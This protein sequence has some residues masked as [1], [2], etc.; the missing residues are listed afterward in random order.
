MQKRKQPTLRLS[1]LS[2]AIALA[3]SGATQSAFAVDICTGAA[4]VSVGTAP[5]GQ[6]CSLDTVDARLNVLGGGEIDQQ[7]YVAAT[8]ATISNAG[9]ISASSTSAIYFDGVDLAASLTNS[10][11]IEGYADTSSYAYAYGVNLAELSGSVNNSGTIRAIAEATG[12]YANASA[13]MINGELS[14]ALNNTGRI[15]A[16]AN[17]ENANAYGVR[18]YG[19]L[20]GKIVNTG[21]LSAKAITTDYH[22]A[23]ASTLYI[24]GDVSGALRNS[25]TIE[26]YA[27]ARTSDASAYAMYLDGD[28]ESTATFTNSG[29][30]TAEALSYDYSAEA[31]AIHMNSGQLDTVFT[32]SNLVSATA[33]SFGSTATAAAIYLNQGMAN[34]GGI[35][36]TGTIVAT[37]KGGDYAYATALEIGVEHFYQTATAPMGTPLGD[38]AAMSGNAAIV[39]SGTILADATGRTGDGEA[40]A[41]QIYGDLAGSARIANTG[42]IK[43]LATSLTTSATAT[44]IYAYDLRDNASILNNGLILAEAHSKTDYSEAVGIDVDSMYD[45]ASIVNRAT[46]KAIASGQ[47]QATATALSAD[48]LYDNASIVNSGTIEAKATSL[49]S[50]ATAYGIYTYSLYDAASVV[51]NG[52]LTVSADADSYAYAYGIDVDNLNDSAEVTNNG[53][54]TVSANSPGYSAY[55]YGITA[56][57]LWGTAALTNAGSVTVTAVAGEYS[58]T[59]YGIEAG[60][61]N[62]EATLTNNGRI[63]VSAEGFS[64]ASAYGISA[65]WLY[66]DAALSNDGAITVSAVDG[67]SS[68]YAYGI[69]TYDLND[70]VVLTNSGSIDV[71]AKGLYDASAYAYGIDVNALNGNASIVSSGRITATA[72]VEGS[73]SAYAYGISTGG[74]T[75]NGSVTNSG[76]IT[77]TATSD[78]EQAYAYGMDLGDVS[79][80]STVTNTSTGVIKAMADGQTSAS[81]YGI[82]AGGLDTTASITNDGRIM[83]SAV[84]HYSSSAYAYGISVGYMSGSSAITNNGDIVVSAVNHAQT[85]NDS[86]YA[87]GID[88]N[89]VNGTASIT[90]D[91]K[92]VVRAEANQGSAYAYGILGGA[93]QGVIENTGT[94]DVSAVSAQSDEDSYAYGIYA[95]GW[96]YNATGL[97]NGDVINSGSIKGAVYADWVYNYDSGWN[98]LGTSSVSLTNSGSIVTPANT[99][100]YVSGDYTQLAG[101]SLGF[102]MRNDDAYAQLDVNGTADFS[103]S[104]TMTVS[105]DPKATF[106]DG[107]LL[108]GVVNVG[109]LVAHADGFVVSDDA[110][111]WDFLVVNEGLNGFDLSVEAVD[112]STVLAGAGMTLSASQADLLQSLLTGDAPGE[113]APLLAALN[114]A[115]SASEAA[116]AVEQFGP[117]L[118]GAASYATRIAG[119]G[120][121]NAISA[122]MGETRGAA[123]GDAF[124]KNAVWI[125][126]FL[127]MAE[128]D[129]ANGLSGYDVDTTGFVIGMDGDIND[130]TRVGVAVASARSDLEGGSANLDIDTTQ[131]TLYGS[132][133]LG[134]AT[135]LDADLSYGANSYDST[136]RVGF[137]SSTAVANYDGTQLSLG[138]TL[139]HRMT[140]SDKAALVPSLSLRYSQVELDGYSETGAAPFNLTVAGADDDAIQAVAKAGYELTLANKGVFLA[141]LGLGYDSIDQASATATVSS[142]GQTFVSNGIAPESTLI[143]GGLGYRY[144]TAKNLEIN[145][146]WDFESRSD[147]MGNALSVKF[148]LPF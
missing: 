16:I 76:S 142:V 83:A 13:L 104:N 5:G 130:V 57:S 114:S 54:I 95:G 146:A 81:A 96:V 23:Y 42:T 77:A 112:P 120:A 122:R 70:D 127:G 125:K 93:T 27:E 36:N 92:I 45:D 141:N 25:G 138:A 84:N 102:V 97:D 116:V 31:Y 3:A 145:A 33:T 133:A 41:I 38:Y 82:T 56:G 66:N 55:A 101:G 65:N 85:L 63:T 87:Y 126:P 2:C 80:T 10:G 15:E 144:V 71:T 39:N 26:A 72:T 20:S 28:V 79:E 7:V 44:A 131:F 67:T 136:R 37:A 121:S 6:S 24:S 34:G 58:A 30:I 118:A 99:D 129:A 86:A 29:R 117:A 90:N 51:N 134:S 103:A 22:N 107:D 98:Y 111:F 8:G 148:K 137:A 113:F 119:Q 105:L 115:G 17:A 124:T 52:T 49:T 143:V 108:T 91:G 123:S 69:Y 59:A 46:L 94:I 109:T 60:D 132:Y 50:S 62:G 47:Q 4:A 106:D 53:R 73:S 35:T 74:L 75:S 135:S 32:N 78:I 14:G 61:L 40:Y 139:S 19:D 68:A 110:L 48:Y 9:V 88:A 128:Q 64:E 12:Y 100:S 43:A 89:S 140:L 1:L 11:L 21:V 147:F 18:V